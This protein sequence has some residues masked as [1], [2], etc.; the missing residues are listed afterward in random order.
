MTQLTNYN[1]NRGSLVDVL[2]GRSLRRRLPRHPKRR[3]CM[4]LHKVFAFL[5]GALLILILL[6][7][8]GAAQRVITPNIGPGGGM[9]P[10]IIKPQI[11]TMDRII[12]YKPELKRPDLKVIIIPPPPP[13]VQEEPQSSAITCEERCNNACPSGNEQCLR[14]CK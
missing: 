10:I 14:L 3:C 4:N 9:D 8:S 6:P 5:G 1:P 7:L 2:K 12:I 13:T 11:G